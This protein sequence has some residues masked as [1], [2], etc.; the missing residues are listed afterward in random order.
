MIHSF[1]VRH[2]GCF[3]FFATVKATTPPA[4]SKGCKYHYDSDEKRFRARSSL[5][6]TRQKEAC[7][8]LCAPESCS[9][10]W[11]KKKIRSN[12]FKKKKKTKNRKRVVW[13]QGGSFIFAIYKWEP[14][15]FKCTT[16]KLV[17]QKRHGFNSLT[18][19]GF[20]HLVCKCPYSL[21]GQQSSVPKPLHH[22]VN[23]A[24]G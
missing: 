4:I 24:F 3:Q 1:V 2:L 11:L 15:W 17:L 10:L 6:G 7:E 8:T 12:S 5:G 22:N 18:L 9:S 19:A 21:W 14:C 16:W 20:A 13:L 23:V